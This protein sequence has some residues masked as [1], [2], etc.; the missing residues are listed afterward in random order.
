MK[1]CIFLFFLLP[2][3]LY[4]QTFVTQP[5]K[6]KPGEMVRV[7]IDLSSSK[8]RGGAQL[9]MV[10]ME[11]AGGK[12]SM[13]APAVMM[14]DEKMIGVFTLNAEA[15]SAVV[16]VQDDSDRWENNT[17]EGYF[18]TLYNQQDKPEPE[19]MVA[20]AILYRDYGGLM[21]LNRTAS[22]SFGLL[23]QAFAAQPELKRKHFSTYI[24]HLMAAKKGAESKD[25]ALRLLAEV[26]VD[27]K[28]TEDEWLAAVR[29]YD[30]NSEPDRSKA[31]KDKIRAAFPKG[32]LVKQE[33]RRAIQNEP[34]LMK[35]ETLLTTFEKEFAPQNEDEKQA[36]YSLWGNLANKI[37]DS[38]NMLKFKELVSKLPEADRASAFNNIAWENAEKGEN[39]EEARKMAAFA[40]DWARKEM[41]MPTGKRPALST[42]KEWILTRKQTFAMYGDTYAFTLNKSGDAKSAAALQ[43]EVIEIT[44]G[45]EAEMNERYTSYLEACGSPEL[46]YKLE[47]FI[48]TGHATAKMKEQ[49]KKLYTAEDKGEAGAAAYLARLEKEAKANKQKELTKTMMNEPA[50]P[51]SLVNLEGKNVSLE[52]LRGKVVVVDFWATWCGPCK[53]SFPGMQLAVN[54]YKNDPDV[55]FVFIDSWEKG[56]DKAKNAQEFITGKGY[57]FNVLMDNEDKVI[58]SYGVSG[59][60]TKFILDRNGKIRFKAIGFE[61]SDEGLAEELGIMIET[62][63]GQP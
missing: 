42:E 29:F 63:K 51:F 31:L 1:H 59:I 40:L 27:T 50:I 12:V 7:E 57:T 13:V 56:T 45:K 48:L 58:T 39:V 38:G 32:T 14:E 55:A 46:R 34:D 6:P 62:A 10:I 17:G 25:E 36:I 3:F 37:A 22:V 53:A 24:N 41:N 35:A 11:Y 28:A 20:A 9:A 49:F 61:G 44:K 47:G 5:S 52:S 15:K 30:R 2:G 16:G 19:G 26:E 43:A 54:Q 8:L 33:K 23:N 4:A 60:P 21:E 18:V